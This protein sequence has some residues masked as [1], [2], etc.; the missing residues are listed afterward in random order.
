MSSTMDAVVSPAL[1]WRPEVRI[2]RLVGS[3]TTSHDLAWLS[4]DLAIEMPDYGV[5][6]YFVSKP[7]VIRNADFVLMAESTESG[8]IVGILSASWLPGELGDVLFIETLLIGKSWHQ[9]RLTAELWRALFE[10]ILEAKRSFP[11]VIALKTCNPKSFAAM[12]VF[13]RLAGTSIYPDLASATVPGGIVNRVKAIAGHVSPDRVFRPETG[14]IVDGGLPVNDFYRAMP[15][16]KKSNI[17]AY[18]E[19]HVTLNDRLLC[20]LF[21]HDDEAARQILRAFG[22]GARQT[23]LDT[24][25]TS[26]E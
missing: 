14:L 4:R 1:A 11:S 19:R 18:F 13:S 3:E 5:S 23:A 2:D 17:Q 9:T 22:C 20:C 24:V 25:T 21:I 8:R 6:S 26:Y 10:S 12:A 7:Q 16:S 15:S